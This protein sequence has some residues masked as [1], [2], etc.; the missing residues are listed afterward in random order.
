MQ[1]KQL[2]NFLM[3]IEC[4]SINKAAQKLY[5]SQPTLSQ[6]LKQLEEELG[7][8]LFIRDGKKLKLSAEGEVLAGYAE[9]H[10]NAVKNL[11][12]KLNAMKYGAKEE[13]NIGIAQTSLIPDVGKW[14]GLMNQKHPDVSYQFINFNF[15]K[16]LEMMNKGQLDLVVTRQISNDAEFLT[17]YEYK[18]INRHGVVAIVPPRLDF[19]DTE[20]ISLKDID[21]EDVIIR[22]KHDKRFIAKCAEY[23]ST[24]IIKCLCRNNLLKLELVKNNV[25]IGFF[26]ES[27]LNTDLI[28]NSNLKYYR[29]KEI[30]MQNTTYVVY[31]RAKKDAPAIR[32]LLDAIFS[33]EQKKL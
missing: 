17:N 19:G 13:I 24:P 32:C 1:T 15:A 7:T 28:K 14:I 26:V 25:G 4:G 29:V 30:N 23:D 31:P 3:I 8:S 16:T 6:Q 5:M 12:T 22:G 33:V 27:I 2:E 21:G 9:R 10:V 18:V 11:I 20:E